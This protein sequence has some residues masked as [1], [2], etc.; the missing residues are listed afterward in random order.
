MLGNQP[1]FIQFNSRNTIWS[2]IVAILFF[3]A[4]FFVAQGIFR[5]LSYISPFL[6]IATL[7]INYRV[8]VDYGRWLVELFQ[9]NPLGGLLGAIFT[10]IGFPVVSA[11]L[12]GK[13][14]LMRKINKMGEQFQQ[15]FGGQAEQQTPFFGTRGEN[16]FKDNPKSQSSDYVEYEELPVE[17]N[18]TKTAEDVK[19][20]TA[21]KPPH[22]DY[23]Q[24]FD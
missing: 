12:F 5:L 4:L 23:E 20:S 15:Q 11:Y 16:I 24:L 2:A 21:S 17:K 1:P 22:N 19:K 14:L 9:R 6:L 13:A 7:I 3:V 18:V 8:V 10:I